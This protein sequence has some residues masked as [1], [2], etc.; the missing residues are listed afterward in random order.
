MPRSV[1]ERDS[2][3]GYLEDFAPGDHFKHW[4]GKTVLAA[5]D[6]L[7]C[8]L[9]M[10]VSPVHVDE[11]YAA[12]EMAGG[13]NHVVGTYVY[14]LLLGM[15]VAQ[16]SGRAIANLGLRELRHLAPLHHGDTL[17]AETVVLS[18]RSSR[19]R[20]GTGILTVRT[21]GRNQDGTMVCEF[22]R[23]VLLPARPVPDPTRAPT[24]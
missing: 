24:R 18:V 15:S 3:G 9:T 21:V 11:H 19:S 20:P 6:H 22:E 23:A 5:D 14:A 12:R 10:A 4:P 13:R 7:F 2:F 17:Y 16:I 8:L 1:D